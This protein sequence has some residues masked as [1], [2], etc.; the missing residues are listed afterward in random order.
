MKKFVS[1]IYFV[2]IHL[3]GL[4]L[5]VLLPFFIP[6]KYDV[7]NYTLIYSVVKAISVIIFIFSFFVCAFKETARG[8]KVALT[9]LAFISQSLPLI[10]LGF[11]QLDSNRELWSILVVGILLMV[12]VSIIAAVMVQDKRMLITDIKDNSESIE[13]KDYKETNK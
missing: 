5:I 9:F 11:Y 7:D 13:I 6:G 8:S 10:V 12:V 4:M 2:I 1:N 3:I